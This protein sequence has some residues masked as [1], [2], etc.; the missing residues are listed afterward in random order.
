VSRETRV[1]R[2]NTLMSASP[3]QLNDI[4]EWLHLNGEP[5]SAQSARDLAL[6]WQADAPSGRQTSRLV[7]FAYTP[8]HSLATIY[9]RY[10]RIS[11]G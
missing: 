9:I 1:K 11:H 3:E 7:E 2:I 5:E 8:D 10:R 6:A 4:A